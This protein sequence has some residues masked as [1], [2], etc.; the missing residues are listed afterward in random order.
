MALKEAWA[1]DTD[2]GSRDPN[3]LN[4]HL[5]VTF[6]ECLG[7]PDHSHALDCV[8]KYSYKCFNMCKL[9]CYLICTTICGIPMA[10]CWGCFFAC[11][12][13]CHVWNITPSIRAMEVN[14]SITKR[15]MSIGMDS[16]V[17]PCCEACGGI[18]SAFKK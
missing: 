9:L 3:N 16:C 12:T 5:K 8:W 6:E 4:D 7:E 15:I 2:L 17:N 1:A 13:F 10:I 11:V 18:F 14:C